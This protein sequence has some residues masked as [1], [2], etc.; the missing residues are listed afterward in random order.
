MPYWNAR[1]GKWIAQ[2]M[3]NGEKLVSQHGSKSAALRWESAMKKELKNGPPIRIPSLLE[4]A[5]MYLDHAQGRFVGKTYSEKRLAFRLLLRSFSP[6][7]EVTLLHKGQVLAHFSR[8]AQ[9][10]SGCAANKDRKN[11]VAAWNWGVEHI[12][13][14][15]EFNPFL[16]DRFA[17]KRR[18]RR[19][20]SEKDFWAIHAAAES[21]QDRTLLLCFLHL[22]ARRSELFHLRPEDVD[23]D[24]RRVRLATMKRKDGSQHYDWL[25]ITSHLHKTLSLHLVTHPGEWVFPNP[26]TGLPYLER[27]KWLPRLCRIAGIPEFGLHGI[28]HL[29]ASILVNAKVSLLDVQTILRHT[30]LTTTQRYVHRLESVRKA[31]E[32]FE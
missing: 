28:R 16:T 17:E 19:I 12:P 30:N 10:R 3:L 18:P 7:A 5:T 23:L 21:E 29:S 11:L 24:R 27:S 31:I 14:F 32:V 6:E 2:V 20:P 13:G 15:P 8:Q 1:R 26:Q 22:A 25:P 9:A 4:W